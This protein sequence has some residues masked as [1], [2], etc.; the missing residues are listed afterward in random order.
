MSYNGLCPACQVTAVAE[1]RVQLE[2][3]EG[4][5]YERWRRNLVRGLQRA[6]MIEDEGDTPSHA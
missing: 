2:T 3:K 1:A 4:E 6:G 5:V